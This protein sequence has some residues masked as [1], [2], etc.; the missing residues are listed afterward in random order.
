[1]YFSFAEKPSSM[2]SYESCETTVRPIAFASRSKRMW[3][4]FKSDDKNTAAGF[5]IPYVTYNGK[6]YGF[7]LWY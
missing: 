6:L 7:A 4:Q 1:M 5:S 2:T 3:I